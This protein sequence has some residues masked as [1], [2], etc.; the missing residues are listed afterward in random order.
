VRKEVVKFSNLMEEKLKANDH[1]GGWDNESIDFLTIR[2]REETVELFDALR[3]FHSNPH[4]HSLKL[5]E[6]ECAD[7]ANFALM[8]SDLASK[9]AS[10]GGQAR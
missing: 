4:E 1:K 8:I 6:D 7:I 5:V 2:L 9:I 10:K 3:I